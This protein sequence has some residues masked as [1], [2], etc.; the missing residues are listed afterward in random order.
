[1]ADGV[2]SQEL[3]Q[4]FDVASRG[5]GE[6]CAGT[7]VRLLTSRIQNGTPAGR[8]IGARLAMDEVGHI[9]AAHKSNGIGLKVGLVRTQRK[10]RTADVRA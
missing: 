2:K 7:F 8:Q 6:K 4:A 9:V 1:M 3:L 10:R 5:G